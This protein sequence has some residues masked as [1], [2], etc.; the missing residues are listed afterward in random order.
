MP[1]HQK[2]TD[3]QV[4]IGVEITRS[5]ATIVLVDHHGKIHHRFYA[6][7]L[8]ERPASATLEP[9]FRAIETVLMHAKSE[10][11][12][13]SG[14]GICIPGTIDLAARRPQ[15]IPILPSLNG[16]PLCDLLEARYNIPA[17]LLVDVDAALV[18][19]YHFG[20]GKGFRRLLFL[21]VNTVVGAALVIDGKLETSEHAYVGHV[22]HLP[23]SMSGPR[24]SC[25]KYGCINSLLSM[26]AMQKMV[27]RALR[28]GEQTN[29]I[30]RLSNREHL[31]PQLLAEEA[32]RGDL[33]ALQVYCEVGRWLGTATAKYIEIYEP[34]VLILGGGVLCA[35]E[36]L[37]A[38]VR[39]SLMAQSSA[40]IGNMLD[41]VPSRLGSDAA[42]IGAGV[43]FLNNH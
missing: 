10:H 17:Q 25:G 14:L 22:C 2:K 40:K 18:G 36:L 26:E 9:F 37:I 15:T 7:T 19:E 5:R 6:K 29:L 31:S 1:D 3:K 11:M 16:F 39:S 23:V 13:I 33:V 34:D 8:R 38:N 32:L 42:L 24:C 12:L 28:R 35:N 30:R 20:A 43:P 41:I 27:Q 4:A 21:N